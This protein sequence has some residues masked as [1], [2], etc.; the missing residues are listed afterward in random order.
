MHFQSFTTHFP[1]ADIYEMI[2]PDLLHQVI[3]GAFK[4]HIVTW[5]QQWLIQAHGDAWTKKIIEDID[6]R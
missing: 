3:K 1:R 5:V 2:T 4:D 6:Y